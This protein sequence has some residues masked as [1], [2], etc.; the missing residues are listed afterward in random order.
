MDECG[1]KFIFSNLINFY[2]IIRQAGISYKEKRQP[3]FG[4]AAFV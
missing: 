3:P 1:Y 2:D 4:I